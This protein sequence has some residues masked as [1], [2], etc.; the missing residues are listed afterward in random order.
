MKECCKHTLKE[1]E[2]IEDGTIICSCGKQFDG[3][4]KMEE[5]CQSSMDDDGVHVGWEMPNGDQV[6][7]DCG[8][9]L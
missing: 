5:R 2:Y 1:F 9:I 3:D 4:I 8:E 6:C 7:L